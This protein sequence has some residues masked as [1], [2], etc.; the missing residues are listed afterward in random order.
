MGSGG[1]GRGV[2]KKKRKGEEEEEEGVCGRILSPPFVAEGKRSERDGDTRQ[3]EFVAERGERRGGRERR[4][5]ETEREE[6]GEEE[7]K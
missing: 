4:G 2:N 6:W 1:W 3:L 5:C 7:R